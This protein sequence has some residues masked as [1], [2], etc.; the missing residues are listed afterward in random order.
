MRVL[1]CSRERCACRT[2]FG[3]RPAIRASCKSAASLRTNARRTQPIPLIARHSTKDR[4]ATRAQLGLDARHRVALLSFGGFGL[5]SLDLAAVDCRGDW[6]VV[7]LDTVPQPPP[8]GIVALDQ[9]T[10]FASG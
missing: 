4:V 6:T 1:R 8:D 5:P 7:T 9:R 10:F 3:A 2:V